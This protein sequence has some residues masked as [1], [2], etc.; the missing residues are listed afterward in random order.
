M[1]L[2]RTARD[3]SLMIDKLIVA[4]KYPR[5]KFVYITLCLLCALEELPEI[6]M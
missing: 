1:S 4:R 3:R 5:E 6:L 2:L